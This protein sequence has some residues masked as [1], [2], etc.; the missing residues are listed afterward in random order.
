[1][2]DYDRYRILWPCHLGLARGKYL[3]PRIAE[4]G[5]G[6]CVTVFGTAYDRD[7]VPAPGA[8]LFEG[9]KD[10]WATMER[11]TL[12]P[13]WEDDRT[14]VAIAHLDFE[15]A[16]YT[17]SSRYALQ[18]AVA[19]WAELGFGVK[20]GIE[21][22]A[23]VMEPDGAGGWK[24]W[25]TPRSFVYATGPGAD[26]EGVIADIAW[27]AEACGFKPESINAEFD[28]AQFELTLE[29]DD[30]LKAA[31]DAFLFRVLARETALKQGLDLTFL[32]KPFAGSSGSG[33]HVNV[34]LVDENGDNALVADGDLSPLAK[35]CLAGL[36]HHHRGMTALCVPTITG[37]RRL[38]PGELNGYWANW[39]YEH[40]CAGNRIPEVGGPGTRIENRLP[41]GSANI[42]LAVTTVLQA[43]RLGV[44]DDLPCPDPMV[45]DG[46]ENVNTDVHS[47]ENLRDALV[48]LRADTRLQEAV[49]A[50]VC[51]NFLVN[52]DAEWERYIA[53]VGEHVDGDELTDW[54][55][56]QYL[57]YH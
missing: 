45:E 28:E 38:Q 57:P 36:T 30:A 9:L 26:P 12:R 39:G 5:T 24:R 41:D 33:I 56:D 11:D 8:S 52:K 6:H 37:Y 55:R 4:R 53:A 16:P 46:F 15:G 1:M 42:H 54:E 50:D 10:V 3:P 49:G 22:E 34:S 14:G 20:V 43:A 32:G 2:T 13:S 47:A 17:F 35:Q 29:Y 23:Y 19:D 18:Q 48:D 31:D 21:L 51:A 7:L 44:V 27:T 40:R 25:E